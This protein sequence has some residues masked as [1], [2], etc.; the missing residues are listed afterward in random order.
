MNNSTK[1]R[2]VRLV[3]ALLAIVMVIGGTFA[4]FTD[5]A[6]INK[7][8]N[9]GTVDVELD[10]TGI[11]LLDEDG[12]LIL[13]PGD[14]RDVDFTVNNKGN[15]SVDIRTI[16]TLTSSVGMAKDGQA[17][18]E[19][20]KLGDVEFVDGKGYMPKEGAQPLQ[21]RS[22]S[23]D[24]RTIVYQTP[25]YILNGNEELDD[26]ER[27][28]EPDVA[29]DID[30]YF[31]VS[32]GGS[33]ANS[34]YVLVF[35]GSSANAFQ[36]SD[37][38]LN[39]HIDAKQHRNQNGWVEVGND[40]TEV[41]GVDED[42]ETYNVQYVVSGIDD[43][44]LVIPYLSSSLTDDTSKF[45]AGVETGCYVDPNTEHP[46]W[47]GEMYEVTD[48][49]VTTKSGEVIELDENGRFI[50]PAEDIIVR[51][52]VDK[53]DAIAVVY[54]TD[55]TYI[56]E[57]TNLDDAF[58]VAEETAANDAAS[59]VQT[60]SLFP[61]AQAAD[62]VH[63]YVELLVDYAL[64][65]NLV[66]STP[67]KITFTSNEAA[68]NKA[69][70]DHFILYT[71]NNDYNITVNSVATM[72]M[73]NV[74]VDSKYIPENEE[75]AER[76][77]TFIYN[78]GTF[79]A[80][81]AAIKNVTSK[82]ADVMFNADGASMYLNDFSL[83]DCYTY[84]GGEI[85]MAL[86]NQGNIYMSGLINITGNENHLGELSNLTMD[87]KYWNPAI[88]V[89]SNF[90]AN[91]TVSLGIVGN[92]DNKNFVYTADKD[93]I[94]SAVLDC[95]SLDYDSDTHGSTSNSAY[96][97][98]WGLQYYDGEIYY[99]LMPKYG[100]PMGARYYRIPDGEDGYS[101]GLN[102][103]NT[104]DENLLQLREV[105]IP[106]SFT[107]TFYC[108]SPYLKKIYLNSSASLGLGYNT[109]GITQLTT[110]D[111]DNAIVLGSNVTTLGR[112]VGDP[113]GTDLATGQHCPFHYIA[114]VNLSK[115]SIR[116]ISDYA[117]YY[118]VESARQK[119]TILPATVATIG[120]NALYRCGA[121]YMSASAPLASDGNTYS[122]ITFC[123]SSD[124]LRVE[125]G[126]VKE[127]L[128]DGFN[129]NDNTL[130]IGWDYLTDEG[131]FISIGKVSSEALAGLSGIE[132]VT[133]LV[134]S[135][136]VQP[137]GFDYSVIPASVKTVVFEAPGFAGIVDEMIEACGL[138]WVRFTN[139]NGSETTAYPV[140]KG[141]TVDAN[142]NVVGMS[143][144]VSGEYV[145]ATGAYAKTADGKYVKITGI[146][147]NAFAG[148]NVTSV[149]IPVG[150]YNI[151][152]DAFAGATKLT[153]ITVEDSRA[154]NE[155]KR[156]AWF[157]S[158]E[159]IQTIN[160]AVADYT[161]LDYIYTTGNNSYMNTGLK[162]DINTDI[163]INYMVPK[164]PKATAAIFGAGDANL[165][166]GMCYLHI[167]QGTTGAAGKPNLYG[168]ANCGVFGQKCT[169]TMIGNTY[170]FY[171]DGELLLER[172]NDAAASF[173]SPQ[174][175]VLGCANA[176]GNIKYPLAAYI[177]DFQYYQNGE[178][179]LD[180]VPAI[181]DGVA[182]M[183]N[184]V[185]GTFK[186]G[187]GSGVVAGAEIHNPDAEMQSF[188]R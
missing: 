182:G 129:P 124:T 127:F 14:G 20:Y 100:D 97:T 178:L 151:P 66:I 146:G 171:V 17:E 33:S 161:R 148:S 12:K 56:G 119:L 181:K 126:V 43:A 138:E 38:T 72:R 51:I 71:N 150:I 94:E 5:S 142:G 84:V 143:S 110:E 8:G 29:T 6:S 116:T 170:S 164:D 74:V 106:E 57:Y 78:Y 187:G 61:R 27:E 172:S 168:M 134:F 41:P 131:E 188:S 184:R 31:D 169:V 37:V 128:S 103:L 19:I 88:Y 136:K 185:D 118:G 32:E 149:T 179:I 121:V 15:K 96:N 22:I 81:N 114:K 83:T 63:V 180:W 53:S 133:H 77:S 162:P 130:T 89:D 18:Y 69:G 85:P 139:A 102:A 155:T 1:K 175:M 141:V 64:A 122:N 109:E 40:D 68:L 105:Y 157:A 177:Y 153:A 112:M 93:R 79:I 49:T 137:E 176:G 2:S 39:V 111:V 60:F 183:Y 104:T 91:S 59:T 16:I 44:T 75:D 123:E 101:I 10:A 30:P 159:N 132:N 70:K 80:D 28:I 120:Q 113:M 48:I 95:F 62:E 7:S 140:V 73:E 99:G 13:N 82:A 50:T 54:S 11:N 26:M 67:Y 145:F 65:E 98:T 166:G 160:A 90:N 42:Q 144:D 147:S 23:E 107:N 58:T 45:Y 76:A 92:G 125:N 156:A 35:K 186:A 173:T 174:A 108:N 4:F 3:A 167:Y 135:D 117:F 115:S 21:V 154:S 87:F 25:I 152:D 46:N 36:A 24:G 47:A 34:K 86:H 165:G 55:R 9:A 163:K 158:N 52:T